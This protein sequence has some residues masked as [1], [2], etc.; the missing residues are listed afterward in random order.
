MVWGAADC[1]IGEHVPAGLTA[2]VEGF[3]GF[4]GFEVIVSDGATASHP[5]TNDHLKLIRPKV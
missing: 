5:V 3:E 2:A 1:D 4:E